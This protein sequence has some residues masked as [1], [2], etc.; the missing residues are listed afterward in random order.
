L[1]PI[2]QTVPRSKRSMRWNCAPATAS[3]SC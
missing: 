1:S 2:P 3:A